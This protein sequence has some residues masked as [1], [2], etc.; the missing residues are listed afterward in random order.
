MKKSKFI[1]LLILPLII[2]SC[3]TF[4]KFDHFGVG[5]T[6]EESF[7]VKVPEGSITTFEGS[8]S[9]DASDDS[10]LNDNI[11]AITQFEVTRISMKITK[12]AS[13]KIMAEGE[14][15]I[16]SDGV[17]VGD[18]VSMNLDLSSDEEV[19]LA[20]TPATFE[21]IKKAYLDKQKIKITASGS[22]SDTP[23]DVEFTIYMSIEA[24]I[25][26]N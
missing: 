18:P 2:F 5:N 6:F 15:S 12:V 16:T 25:Q 20:I 8:A 14:V 4:D 13:T 17:P 3:D 21:A 7:E 10:T 26:N 11:D 19:L 24:T 22:V 9:F 1:Y 23:I